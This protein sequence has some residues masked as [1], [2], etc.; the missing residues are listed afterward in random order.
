MDAA[1]SP[2]SQDALPLDDRIPTFEEIEKFDAAAAWDRL[3]PEQ[4]REIGLLVVRFGTIGQCDE[5][6][7]ETIE[8]ARTGFMTSHWSEEA[9][10][11]SVLP[12]DQIDRVAVEAQKSFQAL[13]DHFDPIW[14]QLFGWTGPAS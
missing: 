10:A 3:S 2:L 4:Q 9:L 13:C 11:Q 5:Y 6:Y 8:E 7:H 12:R 1:Q 14:P